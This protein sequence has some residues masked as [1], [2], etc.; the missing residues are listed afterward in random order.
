VAHKTFQIPDALSALALRHFGGTQAD[1]A[2]ALD[3]SQASMT[4][5]STGSKDE[6]PQR[7]SP[8]V[9]QSLSRLIGPSPAELGGVVVA[10]LY[11]ELLRAGIDPQRYVLRHT[12]GR[13]LDQLD[14]DK[15]LNADLAT[16]A[17]AAEHD[18]E[19]AQIIS[20][21]ADR[22]VLYWAGRADAKA[23]VAQFPSVARDLAAEE[24]VP[25]GAK[26]KKKGSRPEV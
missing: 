15:H 20:A 6:P 21:L 9:L 24:Q 17:R 23:E 5:L 11:D 7:L 10:H 18:P 22:I 16:I 14:L 3:I 25:Y 19:V 2:A 13:D 1:L 12:D 26:T 8:K 4:N